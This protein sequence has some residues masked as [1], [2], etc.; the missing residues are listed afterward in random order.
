MLRPMPATG[1]PDYV[2]ALKLRLKQSIIENTENQSSSMALATFE[3][4]CERIR[5][6]NPSLLQSALIMMEP[7]A[8]SKPRNGRYFHQFKA[9]SGE[10]G[11]AAGD[12]VEAPANVFRGTTEALMGGGENNYDKIKANTLDFIDKQVNRRAEDV[13]WVS[14][15]DEELLLRDLIF[16]FQGIAGKYIRYDSRSE[17]YEI[18]SAMSLR[19]AVRDTV[20][21]LCE[22]GWLYARVAAYIKSANSGRGSGDVSGS[23]I[24]KG[25]VVQSFGSALEEE[26]QDYF[27]LLSILENEMTKRSRS[28]LGPRVNSTATGDEFGG[29][30]VDEPHIGAGAFGSNESVKRGGAPVPTMA[31][32][33]TIE[34]SGGGLT[35]LRLRMWMQEPLERLY[36]MARLVDNAGP[37]KGG[38]LASRLHG[39][40]QNGDPATS[41]LVK[42]VLG[43]VCAPIYDMLGRWVL[44]GELHD[45]Y[46]EFFVG[47]RAG[48][49][50]AH[51]WQDGYYLRI[52]MLPTYLSHAVALKVLVIGKSINFMR[53]CSTLLA[54]RTVENEVQPNLPSEAKSQQQRRALKAAQKRRESGLKRHNRRAR[55]SVTTRKRGGGEEVEDEEEEEEE[56]DEED[57]EDEEEE[58]EGSDLVDQDDSEAFAMSGHAAAAASAAQVLGPALSYAGEGHLVEAITHVSRNVNERLLTLI[59][60]KYKVEAHLHALKQFLLLSQGDFVICLMDVVGPELKKRANQLYRHNLSGMLESALRG[61]NAQYLPAD[62]LDRVGVKLLQSQPGDTGWEV[63]SLDYT[64]DPPLSAVVHKDASSKYRSIFYLLW[65]LKRVEWTLA[66]AWKQLLVFSHARG[67]LDGSKRLQKVLHRCSLNRARMLHV[68]TTINTYLM[69]EVLDSEWQALM[70]NISTK[71]LS[72]DDLI[73]THDKYLDNIM[74]RALLT[75]S[76]EALFLQLQTMLQAVLRFCALEETLVADAMAALARKRSRDEAAR[77]HDTDQWANTSAQSTTEDPDSYDGVP[78][79]VVHRIDEAVRDYSAQFDALMKMLEI[80]GDSVSDMNAFLV[81]RLDFN[82]YHAQE[83]K[84]GNPGVVTSTPPTSGGNDKAKATAAEAG[85]SRLSFS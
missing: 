5:Q 84:K 49:S 16:I 30:Q 22:I 64:V 67:S 18:S 72:L 2:I 47:Q 63:F 4:E 60:S 61:S 55:R 51:I 75:A 74:Q 9:T 12:E 32:D 58:E 73:T 81:L 56:E 11:E 23:S 65:R 62:V 66:G 27:R 80:Q 46:Q 33:E 69:F 78:A 35:L 50:N 15:R 45:P 71:V 13:A 10:G 82:E 19:P 76:D 42:R 1:T 14:D 43:T 57:E 21:C 79:Y 17:A 54:Q 25:I 40:T 26:L 28:R 31:E 59:K 20:F 7:L 36:L 39:H 41:D 83:K 38:A 8:F 34:P 29:L 3:K 37:L 6:V 24:G 44:H 52:A 70:E 77:R 85:R 53:I 48:V 68:V